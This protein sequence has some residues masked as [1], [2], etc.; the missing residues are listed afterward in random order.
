VRYIVGNPVRAGLC[1]RP[2]DWPWSS[3]PATV[4]IV[5]AP[6]FLDV[7]WVRTQFAADM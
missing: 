4:G 6:A 2:R 1:A 3:A 7:G 5:P